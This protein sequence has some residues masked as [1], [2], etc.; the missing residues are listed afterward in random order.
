MNIKEIFERKSPAY[1]EISEMEYAVEQYIFIKKNIKVKINVYKDIDLNQINFNPFMQI[2]LQDEYEKLE[3]AFNIA[4]K[5]YKN[6]IK[7]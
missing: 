6:D 3:Y 2:K 1:Y 7:N 5:N 4:Q